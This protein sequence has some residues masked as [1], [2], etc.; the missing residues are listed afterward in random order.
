[1]TPAQ[2]LSAGAQLSDDMRA[3]VI[4]AEQTLGENL[5]WLAD[6]LDLH[7]RQK[8]GEVLRRLDQLN[9]AWIALAKITT[10]LA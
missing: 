2:S 7:I 10:R 1:M 8:D 6:K 3:A 5:V 9:A 4:Q